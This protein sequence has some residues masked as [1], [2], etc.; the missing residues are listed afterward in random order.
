MSPN[1]NIYSPA[2]RR[3]MSTIYLSEKE[4]S[5][6]LLMSHCMRSGTRR[7]RPSHPPT[8]APCRGDIELL[9]LPKTVKDILS[10]YIL[11]ANPTPESHSLLGD[12][13]NNDKMRPAINWTVA[14]LRQIKSVGVTIGWKYDTPCAWVAG[15]CLLSSALL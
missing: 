8:P 2:L 1:N 12:I 4:R 3:F 15:R 11:V 14:I 6:E 7:H 13:E 10:N 9:C 5:C